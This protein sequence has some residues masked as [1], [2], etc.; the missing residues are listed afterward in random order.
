MARDLESFARRN[1]ALFIGAAFGVGFLVARFLKS[2]PPE[3]YTA[4][5]GRDFASAEEE[6]RTAYKSASLE[7]GK[8]S[9]SSTST[10]FDA[11]PL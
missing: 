7:N 1:P 10:A 2:T 11:R 5:A 9:R 8:K 3:S 6:S 4:A